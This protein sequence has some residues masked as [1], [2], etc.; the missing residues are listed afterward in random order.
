[1]RRIRHKVS[2][3]QIET[4]YGEGYKLIADENINV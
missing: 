2:D 3:I 4:V 1:M